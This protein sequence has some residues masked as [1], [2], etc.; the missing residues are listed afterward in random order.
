MVFLGLGHIQGIA[1]TLSGRFPER[2]AM[3]EDAIPGKSRVED[4]QEP[5]CPR[6]Y[7][8][9]RNLASGPTLSCRS[10]AQDFHGI[11][12]CRQIL[13]SPTGMAIL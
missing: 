13:H 12:L 5:Q 8:Y 4:W 2:E 11:G 10:R 9:V 6:R 7:Y 1:I 3:D